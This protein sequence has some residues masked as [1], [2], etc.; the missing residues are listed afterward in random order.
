MKGIKE[1]LPVLKGV[2][3]DYRVIATFIGFLLIIMIAGFIVNY[4]KRPPRPKA[5][6]NAVAAPAAPKQEEEK[7]ESEE[8]QEESEE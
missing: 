6:K 3:L 2:L 1:L 4:K 7:N 8:G 5:K